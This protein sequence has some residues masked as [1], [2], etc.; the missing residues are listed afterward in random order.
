MKLFSI[1]LKTI[2]FKRYNYNYNKI[3]TSKNLLFL[4]II[5]FVIIIQS[6]KLIIK[7]ESNENN[8]D[9]NHSKDISNRKRLTLTF[10]TLKE[11]M[12][13]KSDL[14]DIIEIN[15]STYY[16]LIRNKKTSFFL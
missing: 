2:F 3:L 7:N 8:F 11:K 15:A 5:S 4:S 6:L 14:I 9:I 10:K 1:Y 12:I 13:Q 16:H